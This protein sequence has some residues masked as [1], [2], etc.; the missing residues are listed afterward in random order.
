MNEREDLKKKSHCVSRIN[1]KKIPFNI[2]R[3][4]KR[5]E[6]DDVG[7]GVGSGTAR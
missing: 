4:G 5:V 2:S 6:D 1:L 7:V 3:I